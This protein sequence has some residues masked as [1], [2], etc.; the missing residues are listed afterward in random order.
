MQLALTIFHDLGNEFV[1]TDVTQDMM[2]RAVFDNRGNKVGRVVRIIGTPE[3]P[4]GVV[5]L[6]KKFDSD[7]KRVFVRN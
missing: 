7:D 6:S 3:Q 5:V 4:M 1:V 2:N